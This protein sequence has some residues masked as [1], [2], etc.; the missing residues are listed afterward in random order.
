MSLGDGHFDDEVIHFKVET[1]HRFA[2]SSNFSGQ[3]LELRDWV[4][5]TQHSIF[6]D[7]AEVWLDIF[8]QF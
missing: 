5:Y 7:L 8:R 4:D 2:D 6:V 3:L 1:L